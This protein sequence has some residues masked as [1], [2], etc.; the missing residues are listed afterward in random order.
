MVAAGTGSPFPFV[1]LDRYPLEDLDSAAARALTRDCTRQLGNTGSCVLEGFVQPSEVERMC[2]E[3]AQLVDAGF[4][5]T[6]TGNAYLDR[7]ADDLPTDHPRRRTETT[8]LSAVAY[9][10]IPREHA[11]RRFYENDT[12]LD[13]LGRAIGRGRLY[14]YECPLGALNISVMGDGDYLRWHFDQSDFVVSLAL[15]DAESGGD[16]EFVPHIRSQDDENYPAVARLLDGDRRDVRTLH[17]P[18]GSLVLFEGRYTIHRVTHT[19]GPM[20]RLMALFGYA[21]RPGVNSSDHLKMIRYG[22]LN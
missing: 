1:D 22:R 3:S 4:H 11:L 18:P 6:L 16:F 14:R 21:D 15:Q 5:N 9:D 2:A 10:R 20:P 8:A 19:G 13:F 17:C 7:P 12:L